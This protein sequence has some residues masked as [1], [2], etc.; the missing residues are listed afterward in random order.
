MRKS[1]PLDGNRHI[2]T[3]WLLRREEHLAQCGLFWC[4]D[5]WEL[6]VHIHDY[7]L[8]AQQCTRSDQVFALAQAWRERLVE[9]GWSDARPPVTSPAMLDRRHAH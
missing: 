5:G 8:L 2:G 7:T 6:R 1:S 9:R 3:L 4:A